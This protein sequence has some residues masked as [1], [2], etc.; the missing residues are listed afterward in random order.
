MVNSKEEFLGAITVLDKYNSGSV[1]GS[2]A[3]FIDVKGVVHS[4]RDTVP[5]TGALKGAFWVDDSGVT[6][7][8][9]T[10]S[11][12]VTITLGIGGGGSVLQ[13]QMSF[14]STVEPQ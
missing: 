4:S 5:T 9:F 13:E 8:K 3:E 2:D 12:G 1:S 11:A 10:D 7:P 14:L 6:L